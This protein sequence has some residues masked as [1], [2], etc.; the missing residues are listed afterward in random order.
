M[1]RD[2]R[3]NGREPLESVAAP[4]RGRDAHRKDVAGREPRSE[5]PPEADDL[6]D[7]V[8]VEGHK[9]DSGRDG[10]VEAG[11]TAPLGAQ[12]SRVNTEEEAPE[13]THGPTPSSPLHKGLPC[14]DGDGVSLEG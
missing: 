1:L 9:D 6:G 2:P 8:D 11:V 14:P 10:G 5:E 4:P 12:R 7:G 13:V 3:V